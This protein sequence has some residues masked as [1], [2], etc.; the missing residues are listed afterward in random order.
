MRKA[1]ILAITLMLIAA[2]AG[3]AAGSAWG[4]VYYQTPFGKVVFKPKKVEFSDLTLTKLTWRHWGSEVARAHGKS[5]VNDCI[6][7]CAAGTIHFGSASV[8]VYRRKTINGKRMYTC[9]K[10]TVKADG[11]KSPVQL[12]N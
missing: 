10:G 8:H 2:T 7:N 1:G 9:I 5:R 6:P 3:T 11:H 4:K 12:C